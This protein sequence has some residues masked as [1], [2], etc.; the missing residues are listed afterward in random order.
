[1]Y[2]WAAAVSFSGS[3][4]SVHS[5]SSATPMRPF[6]PAF[7]YALTA[8]ACASSMCRSA[9]QPSVALVGGTLRN[10]AWTPM[11]Y[12]RKAAFLGS[13]IVRKSVAFPFPVPPSSLKTAAA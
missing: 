6:S 4:G 7:L 8:A 12:P 11:A 10:G 5:E 1:M 9:V 2:R 3:T 13:F